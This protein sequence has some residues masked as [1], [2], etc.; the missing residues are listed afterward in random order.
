MSHSSI[1]AA[2]L[3]AAASADNYHLRWIFKGQQMEQR[4]TRTQGERFCCFVGW[5][6]WILVVQRLNPHPS[7]FLKRI[8][9]H[10][11]WAGQGGGRNLLWGDGSEGA[12][13]MGVQG[14]ENWGRIEKMEKTRDKWRE[15]KEVGP[16]P[17]EKTYAFKDKKKWDNS[18][19]RWSNTTF[20]G[21]WGKDEKNE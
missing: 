19:V 11:S 13:K 3:S 15:G 17:A 9:P 18:T 5:S 6:A 20:R 14:K 4:Q 10:G 16:L 7:F 8:W 2:G 1:R 21:E 12:G